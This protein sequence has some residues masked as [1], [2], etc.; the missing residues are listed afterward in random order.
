[1]TTR[2]SFSRRIC[3][4]CPY[5]LLAA[6]LSTDPVDEEDPS[7][8]RADASQGGLCF[9]RVIRSLHDGTYLVRVAA[10]PDLLAHDHGYTVLLSEEQL[11]CALP[12]DC[13]LQD[14]PPEDIA[15]L[16]R[17]YPTL[18]R[19]GQHGHS[20]VSNVLS[21]PPLS[22]PSASSDAFDASGT[23]T[24]Q[25]TDTEPEMRPLP[26]VFVS[27]A[28]YQQALV[29]A[30]P[31][32]EEGGPGHQPARCKACQRRWLAQVMI[33]AALTVLERA[34]SHECMP[35]MRHLFERFR[36]AIL[37]VFTS[38][39]RFKQRLV[40]LSEVYQG[41]QRIGWYVQVEVPVVLVA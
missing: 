37:R 20:S 34:H 4:H 16:L 13:R 18:A 30:E 14:R 39:G 36:Q 25:P 12:W 28:D 26:H 15:T 40:H 23:V 29:A 35:V 27:H 31:L 9:V 1:M 32:T 19:P 33:R 7:N 24:T 22:D 21:S 11:A 5:V 2:S 6:H 8:L 3:Y 38:F 10:D 41:K 17:G